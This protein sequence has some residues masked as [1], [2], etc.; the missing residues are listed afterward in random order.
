MRYI[1]FSLVFLGLILIGCEKQTE[2]TE[3]SKEM[4]MVQE[5]IAK[6]APTELKYDAASLD[7]RQEMVV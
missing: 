2:Q 7:E 6:F 4:T 5:T 1:S 3:E